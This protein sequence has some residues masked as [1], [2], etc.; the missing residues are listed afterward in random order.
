MKDQI[1]S[2]VKLKIG[3]ARGKKKGDKRETLKKREALRDIARAVK[4]HLR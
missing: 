1:S 4:D 3:V 2:V